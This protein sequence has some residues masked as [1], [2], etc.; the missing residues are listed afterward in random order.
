MQEAT[1]ELACP[2][3][4]SA[5]VGPRVA[6]NATCEADGTR[7]IAVGYP[8]DEL[9]RAMQIEA[10]LVEKGERILH[11][12]QQRNGMT[13]LSYYLVPKAAPATEGFRLSTVKLARVVPG[14]ERH[15]WLLKK[16]LVGQS[17]SCDKCGCVKT[18]RCDYEIRYRMHAGPELTE[19]PACTGNSSPST[20]TTI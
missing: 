13:V 11:R 7:L 3:E 10:F 9:V 2:F 4:V 17:T 20:E 12:S 19:R 1:Y 18:L 5:G 14:R 15:R 16:L 8:G 6:I